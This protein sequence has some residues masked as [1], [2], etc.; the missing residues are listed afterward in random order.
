ML[1]VGMETAL[2]NQDLA[3]AKTLIPLKAMTE[4]H[5]AELLSTTEPEMVFRGQSLMSCGDYDHQHLYLLH[6]EIELVDADGYKQCVKATNSLL[7]IAHQQPRQHNAIALTDCS[8]LRLDSERV[9]KLLAWSQIAEYLL[10]DFSYQPDLDE[11]ADWIATV[12]RSNLFFKVPPTNVE[13]IFSRFQPEVVSAG[14]VI[15]R[16]G[17][18]GDKCYFIKE[19]EAEVVR[20]SDA[21][22]APEHV[23]MIGPGRCFGEDALVNET[24]RNATVIMRSHGVLMT[25][26]KVDFIRLLKEPALPSLGINQWLAL[27]QG[28]VVSSKRESESKESEDGGKKAAPPTIVID[29]RTE[30]EYAEGHLPLAINIP[31]NLLRIKMRQLQKTADYLVYC[32]TGRRSGALAHIMEKQG[33]KARVLHK[34]VSGLSRELRK[35]YCSE[36]QDYVLRSGAV[37]TGQY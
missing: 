28:E 16:Q 32:E 26:A 14:D 5:L 35:K 20:A 4:R 11:D 24:V 23:A 25:L 15:L 19:G 29:A 3:F 22:S 36:T 6:G 2:S 21:A 1:D 37:V 30:E 18:L 8:V 7:P 12:L 17:E 10:L 33:F 34:G 27:S 9:D 31:L 13:S